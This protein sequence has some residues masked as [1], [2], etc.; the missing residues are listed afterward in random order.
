MGKGQERDYELVERC[1]N[2]TAK[3]MDVQAVVERALEEAREFAGQ[4]ELVAMQRRRESRGTQTVDP[5]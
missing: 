5:R 1:M 4:L 2:V 3:L